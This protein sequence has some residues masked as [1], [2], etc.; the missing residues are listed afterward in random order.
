MIFRLN[1]VVVSE[2][3]KAFGSIDILPLP[4]ISGAV[5]CRATLLVYRN[6]VSSVTTAGLAHWTL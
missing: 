6:G 1:I 5:T 2:V 3:A 4:F